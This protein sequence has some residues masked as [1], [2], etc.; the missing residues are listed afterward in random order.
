M[1]FN[2]YPGSVESL[3][4]SQFSIEFPG[5]NSFVDLMTSQS[6]CVIDS[7]NCEKVFEKKVDMLAN[8]VPEIAEFFTLPISFKNEYLGS[9]QFRIEMQKIITVEHLLKVSGHR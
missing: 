9:H 3:D 7:F 8:L 5:D 1:E 6:S 2:I 4:S